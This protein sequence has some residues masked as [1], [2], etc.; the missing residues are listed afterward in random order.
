MNIS[1]TKPTTPRPGTIAFL[2]PESDRLT[3]TAQRLDERLKGLLSRAMRSAKF[4]GK[5]GQRLEMLAPFGAR[6][7]RV[8]LIGTG[9]PSKLTATGIEN[10][11]GR[12]VSSLLRGSDKEVAVMSDSLIEA[13]LDESEIA[14]RIGYGAL[15]RSY[16]FDRY[17][18]K[19]KPAQKPSL[20]KVIVVTPNPTAARRR[21]RPLRHI[22]SGVFLTRDLVSEPANVLYPVEFARRTQDL[23]RLGVKVSILNE[24]QLERLGMR[25][26]LGVGQG[27]ERESRVVVMEWKGASKKTSKP[28]AFVGKGVTFDSGGISIKPAVGMEQMK[29]D[30]G[31]AGAVTGLM[32]ALAARKAKVNAVG[33]IGLV[34][35]MP[36]GTA[37]RPGDVVKS[38][39]GQTI[40]VINTDAEGRLVLADVLWYAQEKYGPCAII[41]LATLTGAIL[42]SLAHEYAGLFSNNDK[43]AEWLIEAG[44]A[45]G[46]EL[47]RMP[48]GPAFDKM[49]NSDI[50]D[51]KNI[52]GRF[53]GSTT[54]AQFL[55][56]FVKNV[57]WA[58]LDIAGVAWSER[59][60]PTAPKGGTGYGVRLLNRLVADY[61]EE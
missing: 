54:A 52:G 16:S 55:E 24:K 19:S 49:I 50:A 43:L 9:K 38:M 1:F 18:T 8:V 34:E 27:S 14:A 35:N 12:I 17:K 37:Q 20:T 60:K 29:W 7:T 42:V 46:E 11:G 61:Y 56:R 6:L 53:A 23:R 36:S 4:T 32:H 41:D 10:A 21:Y 30:M 48:L 3:H 47:W 15:L 33:L 59:F 5:A 45:E 57:P 2:L 13:E 44:K 31:G 25:A 26:L 40:E 51:M 28:I 22:T 39:S 58:H